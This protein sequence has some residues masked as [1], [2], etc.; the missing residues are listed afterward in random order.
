MAAFLRLAIVDGSWILLF[1]ATGLI[2]CRLCI[3]FV[4]VKQ[5]LPWKVLL[6]VTFGGTSGMVIWV[7]DNNL[8]FT[9]PVFLGFF[10]LCT[11]GER[12]GRLA[13][14]LI[15]FCL[16]MSVCAMLDTY[17]FSLNSYDI[18][19]RLARPVVFGLLLLLFRRRLPDGP[20][21]LPPRLWKL[22][23]GLAAMPLCAL[24]AVVLLTNE[25]YT[26]PAVHTLAMNQGLVVLPFV[27][28]TS[29]VLLRAI[30]VLADH[31]QL[32]RT[33]QLA[34]MRELYYQGLRREQD[35]V[36]T[37][38]HDLRNH[39]TALQGLLAQGQTAQAAGYLEQIAGSP[40][41]QG[42][43][44]FCENETANVVLSSKA[45]AARRL[46]LQAEFQAAL[47]RDLPIADPDLCALLGNAIDNAM[48]AAQ[49]AANKKVRLRCRTDKGLFMLQVENALTGDERP[50]LS[51]TKK[52]KAAHGF[53][54]AGMREIAARYGGSLEAG[55]REGRFE[56]VVCLPLER[57]FTI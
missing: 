44:Q 55:P 8:L 36:R 50:D 47:P 29:L 23:L 54:L 49:K 28:V 33:A 37:L 18:I 26:S 24:V 4:S 51:T 21:V 3:S 1:M 19:T 25:K 10:F 17:L 43:Q 40:W 57:N 6:V 22:V 46:G 7:G 14:G 35:Q 41:A 56:L 15:F 39:L 12:L 52:D 13:V 45:E 27:L 5:K 32:A 16:I 20:A 11:Q 30:R 42:S 48:E 9:L 34:E 53:G 2:L 31:Q 38:R